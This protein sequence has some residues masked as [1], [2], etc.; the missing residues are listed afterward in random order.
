M[1]TSSK[2]RS[3]NFVMLFVRLRVLFFLLLFLFTGHIN[4]QG[5]CM[6]TIT[7]G[8]LAFA[9]SWIP[10]DL[11]QPVSTFSVGITSYKT[12]PNS[13]NQ[14]Q[15]TAYEGLIASYVRIVA[16]NGYRSLM[17]AMT[18][19]GDTITIMI[20]EKQTIDLFVKKVILK[21]DFRNGESM[22]NFPEKSQYGVVSCPGNK[23]YNEKVGSYRLNLYG[24]VENSLNNLKLKWSDYMELPTTGYEDYG[25]VL[26][27]PKYPNSKL[28]FMGDEA[29]TLEIMGMPTASYDSV[30]IEVADDYNKRNNY[31]TIK[32]NN[33]STF[34]RGK[35]VWVSYKADNS[36]PL[37]KPP[38]PN[39]ETRFR[40]R[41][42]NN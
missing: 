26:L 8:D 17:Q 37:P 16:T 6:H 29:K 25:D 39:T 34:V 40:Y 18:E 32:L 9:Y 12:K 7:K 24:I 13:I 33:I 31:K 5:A 19:K 21:T 20:R 28:I 27:P 1:E 2:L 11:I 30:Y 35:F 36:A 3:N 14:S 41:I 4:A 10:K 15:F 23:P 38:K 42:V 22:M